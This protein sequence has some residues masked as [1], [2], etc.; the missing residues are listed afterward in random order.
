MRTNNNGELRITNVGQ[1]V[2]LVGW[3]SKKRDLGGLVF[4]DLRDRYGITQLVVKPENEFY[5]LATAV[6]NEYVLQATGKVV[7]RESKNKNIPTGEIEID[8]EKLVV[9]NEAEQPPLEIKDQTDALEDTRMKYRYL[10][11]RRPAMYN[12]L[13]MRHKC[14]IAVRNYF[15]E[16]DFVEVETP[17]LGKSTPEGA[18]DFLVPSRVHQGSYYALPQSPQMYKQLLMV[19]GFERYFQIAKCFRDEDLRA[20]RQLEF[21]QIDVEMSF[22]N[23][24]DIQRVTEGLLKRVWKDVL[25]IDIQTPFVKMKYA[26]AMNNYGSDK[27]DTRFEM[28]LQDISDWASTL[29]FVVFK[30]ALEAKGAVKTIVVKDAAN[31]YSRKEID[32]L[33]E[34]AKKYHAH[35]LAWLKYEN[36]SFSGSIAKFVSE[37]AATALVKKLNIENNDL[38]LIVADTVENCNFSLGALR[39]QVAREMNLID[40]SKFNFLWVVDWPLFE[41]NEDENR[42]QAAHH[43]FTSPKDGDEELLLTHPELCHA[44]AYDVVLNGYELGGGSIRIHNQDIQAKMFKAIGLSDEE[45]KLQFS[46]FVDAL[47]YGTPPHGGL[48]IGLD[49][50]VMIMTGN[51]NLREVIAFPK[52]ASAKCPMSEAPTPVSEKQLAELGIKNI[53]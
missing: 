23:E 20:D 5:Q 14:T 44:K 37:E 15:D 51:S 46:F 36:N 40:N 19:A 33:T 2:T 10:D 11:L 9:I 53:K 52:A 18:R 25:G 38:V 24:D 32:R 27:P 1:T 50:L 16:L 30:N 22:I 42:Y 13:L 34:Y 17:F 29:E 4:I 48:A 49:R 3:C 7:E 35:G 41:Y 8:V 12:N 45:V 31:K 26:D 21:T 39:L 47:K 43:P 6:K 28:L